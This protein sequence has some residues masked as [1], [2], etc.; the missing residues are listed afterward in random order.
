MPNLLTDP[1]KRGNLMSRIGP[2]NTKSELLVFASLRAAGISFQKHYKRAPGTPDVAKPRKRLAVFVDGDFWHGRELDR[3]IAKHGL[4]SHWV[5]K[6]QRNMERDAEQQSQL[7]KMGW[8]VMRVW[9]SDLQ[10]VRTRAK[11]LAGI[12]AFLRSK[13]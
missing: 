5:L 10:R 7:I 11:T 2:K 3:V 12:E 9:D 1:S 13:D 4:D 8:S 6:L